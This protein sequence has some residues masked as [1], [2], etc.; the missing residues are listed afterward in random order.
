M[1]NDTRTPANPFA[2]HQAFLRE[3]LSAILATLLPELRSDVERALSEKGKLL[4]LSPTEAASPSPAPPAG[5][6]SLLTL[7][8]ALYI[9]SNI[10]LSRAGTVALAVE[11]FVCALDLLDD[12]ED[13]DQTPVVQE[14]GTARVLN[15]ATA[16][17][18]LSKY[19]LL[20]MRQHKASSTLLLR[21]LEVFGE[22]IIDAVNGQHGDLLAELR[23]VR[24]FTR[25][26]C[27]QIAA[28]K[29][30]AIMRL[31]CVSGAV[32]AG[33]K[34][35]VREQFAQLGTMLG[36]ANQLD[37]DA[38]DLYHLLHREFSL[39][40]D[41]ATA[42]GSVKSDLARGKKTLPVVLAALSIA[43]GPGGDAL[44][45]GLDTVLRNFAEVSDREKKE[46]LYV[47]NEGIL[48]TWGISLLYRESAR[49][50]LQEI[51][52]QRPVAAELRLLMGFESFPQGT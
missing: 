8:I 13:E 5:I 26:E 43:E 11:C 28:G 35:G 2:A 30:G 18:A 42:H 23:P 36:I 50:R 49:E 29:A 27:I 6:W 17:L 24:G 39:T 44:L 34:R 10:D 22:C 40:T 19:S 7:L 33:A 3:R 52:A 14:L 45:D 37:N 1:S 16:L 48:A 51:E 21:L 9:D 38:H 47:L 41:A 12:I 20:S 25:E 46:Y 31:A 15:V 32:C 4:Y